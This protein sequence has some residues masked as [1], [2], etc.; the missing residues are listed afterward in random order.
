MRLGV[1]ASNIRDGGGVTHV[2]CILADADPP[3]HGISP[4]TVW[5]STKTA[6]QLPQRPWLRVEIPKALD[7]AL[8]RRIAW[9][10]FELRKAARAA[11]DLLWVPGGNAI[12]GFHPFVAM[13]RNM[14]PF[15]PAERRRYG[16]SA[17]GLRIDLL[18]RT[19]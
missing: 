2:A 19:Q 13:C 9:Q 3:A 14:L 1:D 18:T 6:A 15:E 5:T 7:G 16:L 17:M 11:C 12:G 8:P 10:C 4:V